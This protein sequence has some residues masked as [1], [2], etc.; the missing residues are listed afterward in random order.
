MKVLF[1][2]F[3]MVFI[4]HI[5]LFI[6][7]ADVKPFDERQDCDAYIFVVNV[8]MALKCVFILLSSV[9][10]FF[11]NF[12][13]LPPILPLFFFT[14]CFNSILTDRQTSQ[15]NIDVGRLASDFGRKIRFPHTWSIHAFSRR[16]VIQ[17]FV[18]PD[19]TGFC[20][21]PFTSSIFEKKNFLSFCLFFVLNFSIS[22]C[23]VLE[24]DG[25]SPNIDSPNVKQPTNLCSAVW[26][27]FHWLP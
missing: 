22:F 26:C 9:D 8:R 1:Y 18:C 17:I 13:P 6:I 19:K 10:Y 16:R 3:S 25:D 27:G 12:L 20:F 5:W 24:I 11:F 21:T 2:A 14:K 4:L 15:I 23:S 7:T